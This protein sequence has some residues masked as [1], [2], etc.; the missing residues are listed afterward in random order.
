MIAY[1]SLMFKVIIQIKKYIEQ[2]IFLLK[3]NQ[4]WKYLSIP[5]MAVNKYSSY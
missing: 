5:W 3:P 4:E 2:S 1:L